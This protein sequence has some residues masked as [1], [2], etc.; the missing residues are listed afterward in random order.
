MDQTS[1]AMKLIDKTTGVT[2]PSYLAFDSNHRFL[3][4]VNELKT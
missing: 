1:G 2:N 3:Y 4:A